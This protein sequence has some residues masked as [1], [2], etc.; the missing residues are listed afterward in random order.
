MGM[1]LMSKAFMPLS[2]WDHAFHTIVYLINRLL[3]AY[4]KNTIPYEMILNKYPDYSFLKVF[5]CMCF[6]HLRPFNKYKL[7]FRL[8]PCT[9]LGYSSHHNGY[10]CLNSKGKIFLS[11]VIIFYESSFPFA[12]VESQVAS[13]PSSVPSQLLPLGVLPITTAHNNSHSYSIDSNI[14]LSQ[15]VESNIP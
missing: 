2:Y 9:F 14:Q 11:K 8:N 13:P 7:D 4:H 1:T 15:H 5:R 10:K 12:I 3:S 6:L